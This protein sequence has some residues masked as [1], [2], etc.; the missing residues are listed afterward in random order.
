L[1]RWVKEDRS[2]GTQPV[3][4]DCSLHRVWGGKN[5]WTSRPPSEGPMTARPAC[6]CL[7]RWAGALATA[8]LLGSALAPATAAAPPPTDLRVPVLVQEAGVW[9]IHDG[10]TVVPLPESITDN[11]GTSL[12]GPGEFDLVAAD[13]A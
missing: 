7:R 2:Q 1:L 4:A 6:S 9:T 3:A 11:S 13:S 5:V 12:P 8:A 10:D